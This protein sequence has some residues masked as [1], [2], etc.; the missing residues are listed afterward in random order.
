MLTC[1]TVST[2]SDRRSGSEAQC[3]SNIPLPLSLHTVWH[4]LRDRRR[5][6]WV[7]MRKMLGFHIARR[8]ELCHYNYIYFLTENR[9]LPKVST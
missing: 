9:E 8:S 4:R 6:A 5:S 1:V 3:E 2:D 7:G